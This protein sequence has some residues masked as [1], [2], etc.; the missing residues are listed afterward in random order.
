MNSIMTDSDKDR[1]TSNYKSVVERKRQGKGRCIG[2]FTKSVISFK[3][4]NTLDK[5]TRNNI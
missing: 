2:P 5:K 1:R 3:R 4:N